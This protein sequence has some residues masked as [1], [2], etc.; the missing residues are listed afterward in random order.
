[1][2]NPWVQGRGRQQGCC[3]PK[4]RRRCAL[5]DKMGIEVRVDWC[6]DQLLPAQSEMV[7]VLLMLC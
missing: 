1:M 7:V 3:G 5:S 2:T 6:K 4:D